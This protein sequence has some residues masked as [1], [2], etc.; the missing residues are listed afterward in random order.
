MDHPSTNEDKQLMFFSKDPKLPGRKHDRNY[1][2]ISVI[3][4]R[5]HFNKRQLVPPNSRLVQNQ[6]TSYSEYHVDMHMVRQ[7]CQD[8]V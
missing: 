4:I 7:I 1:L 2:L 6:S 5:K 3:L 8:P